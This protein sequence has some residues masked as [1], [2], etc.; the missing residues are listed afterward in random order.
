MDVHV[1]YVH[2]FG[3]NLK[4]NPVQVY[5]KDQSANVPQRK[6]SCII[7]ESHETNE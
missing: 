3:S 5:F 2:K 4:H 6:S 1:N 7:L